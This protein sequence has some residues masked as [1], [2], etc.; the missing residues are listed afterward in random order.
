MV[1]ND[2][3]TYCD[4]MFSIQDHL[5]MDYDYEKMLRTSRMEIY[6][7]G[8]GAGLT[9]PGQDLLEAGNVEAA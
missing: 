3:R 6:L 2:L 5:K 9:T 4:E 1:E 7:L 8:I